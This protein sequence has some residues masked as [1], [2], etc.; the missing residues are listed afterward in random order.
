[1]ELD[2]KELFLTADGRLNRQ[3]YWIGSIIVTVVNLV[4]RSIVSLIFGAGVIGSLLSLIIALAVLYPAICVL[5]KRF[6]DRD[7][8]GW[9]SLLILVP[10]IGWIWIF[11]EAGCLPGTVGPNQYGP[12]PLAKLG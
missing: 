10:I 11:V 12:D 3:P 1:M 5:I 9:W 7:K 4:L 2:Y 8:S 6:H